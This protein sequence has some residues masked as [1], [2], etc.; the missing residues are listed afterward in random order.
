MKIIGR[1]N[2]IL[3][4]ERCEKTKKS[5]LVCV[6]GRRRVGKTYLIE[7]TFA[8]YFAFRATGVEGGNKTVQLESF[9][10]R[11]KEVG[12]TN[13]KRPGNWFEAFS[14]LEKILDSDDIICSA[15]GKR[16]V[17]FD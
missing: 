7:Q 9:Y 3:E 14:R 17:F 5:E 10:Q 12:D 6:Y 1:R 16:I 15:H 4:L 13:K 11:L 2:E 8:N